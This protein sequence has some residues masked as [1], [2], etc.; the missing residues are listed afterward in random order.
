LYP[1][2]LGARELLLH[3][4]NPYGDDVTAEIQKGYYG[5]AIDPARPNDPKDQQGFAYPVYV[6]FLLSPLIWLQFHYVQLFFYW[7][8]LLATAV[9]VLLWLR[10]LR[11]RLPLIATA[12]A[13]VL[14]IGSVPVMQGIKLQQLSLLIAAL[15]TL[16]VAC[17]SEGYFS[18][19]GALLALA[20]I[21]PQLAWAPVA[22]LLAWAFSNW[23]MRRK[24]AIAFM[25]TMALLLGGAEIVLPDWWKMFT[26]AVVRY[27]Q[28]TQNQSV[29]E[30]MLSVVF[31]TNAGNRAVHQCAQLLSLA[32]V[33]ACGVVIWKRRRV[34]ASDFEFG[35]SMALVL[36][37]SVLV[38]PMYVPYNQILLLPA[39][40]VLLKERRE[41]IAQAGTRRLAF[42]IGVG[43]VAWQWVASI[44]LL[45]V[46]FLLSRERALQGWTW[47]FLGTLAFPLWIFGLIFTYARTRP[48]S[49]P[50]S[51]GFSHA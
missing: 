7:F 42:A 8:L 27:H 4:R 31:N 25:V 30:A 37:L 36:A 26:G 11:W 33:L 20:T 40:F 10:V 6:V 18:V 44:G 46:Y 9:S 2:W 17:I 39:I 21:K 34:E 14:T 22:A 48:S 15:M 23:A 47:P 12:A 1:R 45:A 28:Y 3:H 19:G 51:R 5:R 38:V 13:V 35:F 49:I 32:A 50:T 24:F 43:I 29:I 41:F 16:S